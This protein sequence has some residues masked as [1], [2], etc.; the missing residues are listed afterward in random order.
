MK[1]NH[2]IIA[3][4][5]ML[6]F[7]G[8]SL[9]YGQFSFGVKAGINLSS[10][11]HSG[12]DDQFE[13]T[14]A[15]MTPRLHIGG[16]VEYEIS[17]NIAAQSGLILTGKGAKIIETDLLF[18]DKYRFKFLPVYLQVPLHLFYKGDDFFI[19][20][21]PYFAFAV[22][23][24]INFDDGDSEP[25]N[26]GN[27]D[28]DEWRPLD[29]GIGIQAGT[30]IGAIRIGAGYDLGLSNNNPKEAGYWNESG[31]LKNSVINVFAAY[32]IGNN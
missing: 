16:I 4:L 27:T 17:E 11:S 25:I 3:V 20:A 8:T 14:D 19:G 1:K 15:K 23:G 22:S 18:D 32:I 30:T 5:F 28:L 12:L 6:I 21:G 2:S 13:T 7:N 29:F 31:N 26:F 9:I 10:L 24:K